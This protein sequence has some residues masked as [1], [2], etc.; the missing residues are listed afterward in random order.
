MVGKIH[1]TLPMLLP[2]KMHSLARERFFFFF[3]LFVQ[4]CHFSPARADDTSLQETKDHLLKIIGKLGSGIDVMAAH[5]CISASSRM[6]LLSLKQDLAVI[7]ESVKSD[8]DEL[9]SQA[10]SCDDDSPPGDLRRLDLSKSKL[11]L[12]KA[13]FSV[14]SEIE[15]LKNGSISESD[16][17]ACVAD[18]KKISGQFDH[19]LSKAEASLD[20]FEVSYHIATNG[21]VAS[22]EKVND[23]SGGAGGKVGKK[24]KSKLEKKNSKDLGDDKTKDRTKKRKDGKQKNVNKDG[25]PKGK[26]SPKDDKSPDG[27][28]GAKH[29]GR[30]KGKAKSKTDEDDEEDDDDEDDDDD[31]GPHQFAT[32]TGGIGFSSGGGFSNGP[33]ANGGTTTISHKSTASRPGSGSTSY[34]QSATRDSLLVPSGYGRPSEGKPQMARTMGKKENDDSLFEMIHRKM[35]LALHSGIISRRK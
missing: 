20:K 33:K 13:N 32:N 26:K 5:N 10:K 4:I 17:S 6:K 8:F 35:R 14:E 31:S 19:F 23:K 12:I 2:N 11:E 27:A 18:I 9:Q 24:R 7:T 16:F 34:Y 29:K 1:Y 22:C 15:T 21:L 28:K 25:R 30:A 3:V